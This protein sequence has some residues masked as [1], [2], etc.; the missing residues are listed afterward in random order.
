MLCKVNEK[1]KEIRQNCREGDGAVAFQAFWEKGP[2]PK[3]YRLFSEAVIEQGCSIG[4]HTHEGESEIYYILEGTATIDD[5]GETI[6]ASKGDLH[7]CYNGAYH[8]VKNNSLE[9]LRMLCV[10]ATEG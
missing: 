9:T 6:T 7:I 5:N 10:I 3:P 2:L 1:T 8:S 4:K